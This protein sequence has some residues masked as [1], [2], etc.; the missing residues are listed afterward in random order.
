MHGLSTI[1]KFLN[2]IH[3]NDR[4]DFNENYRGVSIL[5]VLSK[6]F[7]RII[8]VQISPLFDTVFWK[9]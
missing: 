1:P 2:L 6:S 8:F 5:P 7:E 3:K 9:Y 4:E